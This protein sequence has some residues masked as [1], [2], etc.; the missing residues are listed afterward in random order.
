MDSAKTKVLAAHWALS[1]YRESPGL[2]RRGV[3]T[4]IAHL[5]KPRA[6]V[7]VVIHCVERRGKILD[8]SATGIVRS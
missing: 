2:F 8:G 5:E 6:I 1:I 4:P 3:S 7:G